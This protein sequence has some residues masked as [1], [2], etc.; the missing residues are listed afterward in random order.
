MLDG[1]DPAV[2]SVSAKLPIASP[3]AR[4]GSH[5]CFCSSLPQRWIEP[6][7]SDPCT[8]TKVRMPESPASSSSAARPYSTA[9]RPGHP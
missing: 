7:A 1:S 2:G 8:E 3:A 5:S 4:R 6:I 9:L